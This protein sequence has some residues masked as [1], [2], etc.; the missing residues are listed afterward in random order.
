MRKRISMRK[1]KEASSP[2]RE[3]APES[4]GA[5]EVSDECMVSIDS[6]EG[7]QQVAP[8]GQPPA[9]LPEAAPQPPPKFMASLLGPPWSSHGGKPTT[10]LLGSDELTE[11]VSCLLQ[12]PSTVLLRSVIYDLVESTK[13]TATASGDKYPPGFFDCDYGAVPGSLSLSLLV[14]ERKIVLTQT[15]TCVSQLATAL[16]QRAERLEKSHGKA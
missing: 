10:L 5:E 13:E 6:Q 2:S 11:S 9:D 3:D 1:R 14:S 15:N 4:Q 12:Q 16:Q 7:E 8:A